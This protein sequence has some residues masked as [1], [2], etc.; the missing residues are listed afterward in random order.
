MTKGTLQIDQS[1]KEDR[2]MEIGVKEFW[3]TLEA[4]KDKETHSP[5][6]SVEGISP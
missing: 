3:P 4:G 1:G 6:K 2:E 5:Q